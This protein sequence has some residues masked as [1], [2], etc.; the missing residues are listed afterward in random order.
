MVQHRALCR[1]CRKDLLAAKA[2][3]LDRQYGLGHRCSRCGRESLRGSEMAISKGRVMTECRA[4]KSKRARGSE[5][6]L[7]EVARIVVELGWRSSLVDGQTVT[8]SRVS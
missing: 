3:D 5:S 8:V 6:R 7:P 1:D 2:A 4:C